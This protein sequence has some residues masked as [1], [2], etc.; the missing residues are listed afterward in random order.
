MAGRYNRM[1]ITDGVPSKPRV[2]GSK[3]PGRA[4]SRHISQIQVFESAADRH[5]RR[6]FCVRSQSD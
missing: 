1:G 4:N 2:G 3:P 6:I 5:L